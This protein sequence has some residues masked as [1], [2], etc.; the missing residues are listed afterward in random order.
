MEPRVDLFH[1][2]SNCILLW[3]SGITAANPHPMAKG[4]RT[5]DAGHGIIAWIIIGIVA[6]WITGKIM[7]GSGF[8]F[9]M[10]MLV[11]L[12]GAVVGGFAA[13]RLGFAGPGQQGMLVSIVIAV[14]G[15]V[16]LTL[17]L[18]LVSGGRIR[19]I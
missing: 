9:F 8:G 13:T 5:M 7:K 14:V 2:R 12:I 19:E 10:D 6:G 15:A 11:G 17:I 16:L 3:E 4:D 18:R 1:R